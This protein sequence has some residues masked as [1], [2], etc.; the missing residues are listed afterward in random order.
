MADNIIEI[1]NLRKTYQFREKFFRKREVH[2]VKGISMSIKQGEIF[3]FLGPNGAGKTTTQRMLA[4][5]L[6]N[7]G[8]SATISG[9]DVCSQANEVRKIIGYVGQN[10]STDK[11]ATGLHNLR[12]QGRLCGL[13][14]TEVDLQVSELLKLLDLSDIIGRLGITYS[15]GQRRRLEIAMGL[16]NSPKVLFLDEPTTGLDPQ[17]RANL[18]EHIRKLRDNGMTILLTTHYLD[19]AD[20][21]CDRIAIIDHG[22]V[23]AIGTPQELKQQVKS[24]EL[25]KPTLDDVFLR[26]TGRALRD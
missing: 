2:A 4:T 21:L 6:P 19:E 24:S 26:M 20:N 1:I 8:G 16:V 7:S 3:G 14:R 18:W 13:S 12:L 23:S 10:G 15:G 5:L 17:N 11:F 22:E 25:P 9:F